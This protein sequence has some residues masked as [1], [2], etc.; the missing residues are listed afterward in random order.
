MKILVNQSGVY[1][2]SGARSVTTPLSSANATVSIAPIAPTA[3][4]AGPDG[5]PQQGHFLLARSGGNLQQPL[6]VNYTVD[7]GVTNAATPDT[8]YQTLSGT[9]TIPAGNVSWPI[10]V[11][12]KEINHVEGTTVV[13]ASVATGSGSVPA[14]SV[15]A[16]INITNT[17]DGTI[18]FPPGAFT[19]GEPTGLPTT[20][21]NHYGR[22][23]ARTLSPNNFSNTIIAP[24]ATSVVTSLDPNSPA[25]LPFI[26]V[27]SGSTVLTFADAAGNA[28]TQ[29]ATSGGP[30]V[31]L[32]NRAG[33][34]P[35]QAQ[36]AEADQQINL[37]ESAD[38]NVRLKASRAMVQLLKA[39][40]GLVDYVTQQGQDLNAGVQTKEFISQ[41]VN[42]FWINDLPFTVTVTNANGQAQLHV[43]I[44]HPNPPATSNSLRFI[45]YVTDDVITP[46]SFTN[47]H[48]FIDLPPNS[49]TVPDASINPVKGL[50]VGS[51]TLT[52]LAQYRFHNP[53]GDD[54]LLQ[55]RILS[56]KLT[57]TGAKA[58]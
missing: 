57:V 19:W 48:L 55:S 45:L 56:I 41:I 40:P 51:T 47:G 5:N 38:P 53:V 2:F 35:T 28:A 27:N 20:F 22:Y 8:E 43:T 23:V 49:T 1:R 31:S 46:I 16:Q 21:R 32:E 26:G 50:R 54:E 4:E 17:D 44:N 3:V 42:S 14:S 34:P 39:T 6:T 30:V 9:V 25:M 29:P 37:F 11:T 36:K 58:N 12:P 13:A 52:V 33:A 24:Q 10:D 15:A 7:T 18:N